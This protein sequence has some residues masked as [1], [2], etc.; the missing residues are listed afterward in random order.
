MSAMALG[1]LLER[2]N[3]RT[4]DAPQDLQS[5]HPLTRA[6]AWRAPDLQA[7]GSLA[8]QGDFG[9]IHLE[10]LRIAARSAAARGNGSSRK[11]SQFHQAAG[12]LTRKI[13]AIENGGVAPAEVDKG[14]GKGVR[15]NGGCDAIDTQLHL[16][17]SMPKSEILV[18]R[19]PFFSPIFF[20]GHLRSASKCCKI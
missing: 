12:I 3:S 1:A 4:A 15:R 16:G 19:Q 8:A 9:T 10:D 14:A 11:E 20:A 5:L 17:F 2:G 18:K 13:D 6:S 7:P